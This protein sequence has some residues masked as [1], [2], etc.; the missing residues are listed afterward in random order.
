[1]VSPQFK[2]LGKWVSTKDCS[3]IET[4]QEVITCRL[5]DL[6]DQLQTVSDSIQYHLL[7]DSI[8][9]LKSK[10]TELSISL[11][12]VSILIIITIIFI[13]KVLFYIFF[14]ILFNVFRDSTFTMMSIF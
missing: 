4:L 8:I 1:M 12:S 10:L 5:N 11:S 14:F 2:Y 9:Q 13:N 3:A 7:Y 6:N